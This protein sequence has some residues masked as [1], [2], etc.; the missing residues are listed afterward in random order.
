[1]FTLSDRPGDVYELVTVDLSDLGDG[2][3]R[4][5]SSNAGATDPEPPGPFAPAASVVV[6]HFA[7]FGRKGFG[8]AGISDLAA[9]GCV[10]LC[11]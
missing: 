8:L 9:R 2:R 10:G 4:C 11:D 6:A 5:S 3:R 1:V 7:Q